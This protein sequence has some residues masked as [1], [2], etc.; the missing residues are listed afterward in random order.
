V[1]ERVVFVGALPLTE[2]GKVSRRDLRTL[3]A[4]SGEA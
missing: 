2:L 1:P 3:L 4:G